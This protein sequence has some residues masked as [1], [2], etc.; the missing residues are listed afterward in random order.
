MKKY[1][2]TA[3]VLGAVL[4]A[5]GAKDNDPVLMKVNGKDVRLSEFEYLYNKNNSQQLEPQTLDEYVGMFADYKRKVADAEAAGLDTTAD[6]RNE[7]DRYCLD[8]IR[9]YL[10]DQAV[11]D[12]LLQ[13]SYNHLKD[14]V[15][16]SHIMLDYG[17]TEAQHAAAMKTADSLRTLLVEGKA[18]YADIARRYSVDDYSKKR[19]GVMGVV[20]PGQYPWAFEDAAY[21]TA[22]GQVSPVVNSG[23]GLHIIRVDSRR[24]AKGEV[25]AAHILRLT[26]GVPEDQHAAVKAKID[27]IYELVKAPG[28]D[29]AQL[30][31]EYSEDGSAQRGGDLGWFG[32]GRMVQPFDSIAFA[33][34]DGAVS[35]PFQTQ[36]GYHIIKRYEHRDILPLDKVRE[37]LLNKMQNDERG[38]LPEQMRMQQLI[39]QY[40]AELNTTALQNFN[41][42]KGSAYKNAKAFTV[43]G[44]ATKLSEVV[45]ALCQ[46]LGTDING[47]NYQQVLDE[48]T[49]M[50][51]K[52]VIARFKDNLIATNP[53]FRNLSK[54]YRDGILMFEIANR[55]VWDRSSKD[56]E[57]LEQYFESHRADYKWDK[58]KY[59]A[60]VIFTTT[61]E[62][63]DKAKAFTDSVGKPNPDTFVSEVNKRFGRDVKVERVIAGQGDNAITDYLG[64]GA[65][66]PESGN[67]RWT[68][69]YAVDGQILDTPQEAIDV[70]GAVTTDYQGELERQWLEE[71]R[72]KYPV[73]I[74]K[75]VLKQ[76]KS[77]SHKK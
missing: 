12:S 10:R 28:T 14:E 77:L 17:T 11:E 61:P 70:K 60:Y 49:A 64:F 40:G 18:D 4:V 26:R 73:K 25:H 34:A 24:P 16:V 63:M 1:I 71:L 22:V 50:R 44:K 37:Q 13:V 66:K 9:P 35:E 59:K 15:R 7:Y 74:D 33:L 47:L 38:L 57:G 75:K 55:K 6:F 2:V 27:S 29:F 56:K 32:S 48:A 36:F 39:A 19:D 69:Y 43:D 62:M 54:E 68:Y 53:E 67:S 41:A 31:K 45:N 42:Y 46:R 5:F 51:D 3:A 58:P 21:N 8:L 20:T 52:A 76:V 72:A 23:F 30:A 65:E